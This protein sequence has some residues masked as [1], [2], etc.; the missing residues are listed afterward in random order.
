MYEKE[1]VEAV[2]EQ[3]EE[4]AVQALDAASADQFLLSCKKNLLQLTARHTAD[5]SIRHK[6]ARK[7]NKEE[8]T[9]QDMPARG[10]Q[11][12]KAPAAFYKKIDMILK[13]LI[14]TE[15]VF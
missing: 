11:E 14:L 10:V 2:Q 7:E 12:R 1:T 8:D 9:T 15:N 4:K 6:D 3:S 13:I 5:C